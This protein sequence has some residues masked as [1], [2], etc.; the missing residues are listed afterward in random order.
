MSTILIK[1]WKFDNIDKA[2]KS[3]RYFALDK[4]S[5]D[6]QTFLMWTKTDTDLGVVPVYKHLNGTKI[7]A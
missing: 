3:K 5:E 6:M 4:Q 7:E 2:A 1:E